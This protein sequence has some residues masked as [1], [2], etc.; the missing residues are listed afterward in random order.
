MS[1]R[2]PLWYL[3]PG[4]ARLRLEC[5]PLMTAVGY[6]EIGRKVE[7]KCGLKSEEAGKVGGE[8]AFFVL[9]ASWSPPAELR[10]EEEAKHRAYPELF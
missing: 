5:S 7:S 6:G 4:A 8:L 2:E 9:F 1:K 3:S 10:V